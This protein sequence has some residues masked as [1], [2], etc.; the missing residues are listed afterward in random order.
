MYMTPNLLGVFAQI[1][2]S[3]DAMDFG[4]AALVAV[5]G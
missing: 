3:N 2:G 1:Y 5:V 4:K